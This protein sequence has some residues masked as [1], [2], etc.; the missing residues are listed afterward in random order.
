MICG[1]SKRAEMWGKV[2]TV[3]GLVAMVCESA[4]SARTSEERTAEALAW[5]GIAGRL[6]GDLGDRTHPLQ[7]PAAAPFAAPHR[8]DTLDISMRDIAIC[9]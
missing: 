4:A 8:V 7:V 2:L 1:C 9:A 3:R 6:A 5:P